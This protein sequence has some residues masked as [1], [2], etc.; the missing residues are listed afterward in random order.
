MSKKEIVSLLK[1]P[2]I[3]LV[4]TYAVLLIVNIGVIYITNGFFPNQVVLGTFSMNAF[5]ATLHSM[6]VLSLIATF[7]IPFF[8]ELEKR[9]GRMLTPKEW[10]VYYFLLNAVAIWLI[11]RASDQFGLGVSSWLVVV[12]LA[13]VFDLVQGA[14]MMQLEKYRTAK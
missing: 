9:R 3:L 14:A 6:A 13:V 7:A 1:N 11:T 4:V 2:G 8:H 5:W 10:M 12:A